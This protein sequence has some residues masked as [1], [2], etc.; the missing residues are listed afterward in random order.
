MTCSETKL[1]RLPNPCYWKCLAQTSSICI[2]REVVSN[3]A[4]LGCLGIYWSVICIFNKISRW[5]A[6][7]TRVSGWEARNYKWSSVVRFQAFSKNEYRSSRG[8]TVR[9]DSLGR[10]FSI[11][12]S[13][14]WNIL[15]RENIPRSPQHTN[16]LTMA[17][18]HHLWNLMLKKNREIFGVI[19][20]KIKWVKNTDTNVYCFFFKWGCIIV[21]MR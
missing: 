15:T 20:W 3:A 6:S 1:V 16:C 8:W 4:S 12:I 17:A 7:V 18:Y 21:Y 5:S 2:T 11:V 14:D 9:L 13:R 19:S 10:T